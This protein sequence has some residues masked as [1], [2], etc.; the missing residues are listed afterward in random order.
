MSNNFINTVEEC[1]LDLK[2]GKLIIVVDDEDRENEGDLVGIAELITPE[3]INFMATEGR[4]LICMPIEN[5]LAQKLKFNQMVS[6][7]TDNHNTAFTVSIDHIDTTTG[8][9]AYERAFTIKKVLE[10]DSKSE[11][12]RRPG[13]IF[14][15]QAKAKGVAQ[16]P[17]HTE[18]A[19][20]LAKLCGYKGAGV[21]CEIMNDDG[22]MARLD[23]LKDYSDKHNL[24]IMTIKDL[25]TY[26]ENVQSH[27]VKVSSADMPT[28]YGHFKIYGYIDTITGK[29]H[30]ALVMGDLTGDKTPLVRMHSECMTG[31]VLGSLRCDCGNQLAE[32]LSEIDK[33]GVGVLLYLRQEGRGI[34]LVN[35]IRAYN[36]QDKG[37]DTVDAN[38]ALGFDEDERRYYMASDMLKDLGVD[39]IKLMTNNPH[40]ISSLEDYGIQISERVPIV[41]ECNI[42]NENY[43]ST[44]KARMNHII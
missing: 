33:Y 44:K 13:H 1:L 9:S 38:T 5:T 28:K 27:V 19:V 41:I 4:G 23:D 14:P 35:K 2:Q 39:N 40:K 31:D 24:K 36:L 22:S 17:G 42:H 21:I 12:F 20:D 11:D 29:E 16:R 8:I 3:G 32:A 25:I 10:D 37:Y 26:I 43:L 15:L 7:N 34:G 6:N 18:A 30:L